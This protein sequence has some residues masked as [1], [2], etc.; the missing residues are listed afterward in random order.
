VAALVVIGLSA[1]AATAALAQPLDPDDVLAQAAAQKSAPRAGAPS[2]PNPYLSFLPVG[3]QPDYAAWNRWLAERGKEKRALQPRADPTKLIL[4]SES[5]PNGTQA[6]ADAVP[7]FGSGVGDDPEAD[8]PGTIDPPPAPTL[9]GPSTEDEGSIPLARVVAIPSGTTL[10]TG[11]TVGDGPYASSGTG[12]GDFDFYAIP[13]LAA[14]DTILIDVDTPLPFCCDLDP[15][16]GIWDAA[17]NLLAFNDD[18]PMGGT[19]DSYLI[20]DVPAA[21][22][23]YVSMGAYLRPFPSNPFDS[24]S[25]LG[26]ASEGPYDLTLGVNVTDND[27]YSLDLEPGD[28]IAANVLATFGTRVTL[29]DPTAVQRIG[30]GQEVSVIQP[31]P[32]PGGGIASF[33][34]VVETAGTHAVRVGNV[35]GAYTLELRVLR[36]LLE[37]QLAGTVQ[38][39]FVDFDGATIDRAIFNA[40]PASVTLSPLSAFLAGWGLTPADENAVIDGVLDVIEENLSS[41]VRVFGANGD[42]D[43]TNLPGDFDVVILNSRDHADPFGAPNVSRLII[44]GTIPELGLS[45]IGIAESIDPG[46]FAT[47]ETAVVLLDLLSGPSFDPNSLNQF[48]VAGSATKVDLVAQG[49]GNVASHEAGHF[50]ANWH[51]AQFNALPCIMD[52]GGNLPG[53]VGVGTDLTLGTGDDVDVDLE[54]DTYVQGEG[55]T[56]IEDTLNAVAFGLSTGTR[57]CP[58]TPLGT[59]TTAAKVS[60]LIKDRSPD[61]K[62]SL[63]F[64][65]QKGGTVFPAELGDPTT[66]ADYRI[67]V[68]DADGLVRKATAP[69]GGIC[70]GKPCWKVAGTGFLY[71]DKE[72]TP[73]GSQ[74]ITIKSGTSPRPKVIWKAKGDPLVDGALGLTL[75]VVVEVGHSDGSACFGA[76]F[77]APGLIK[78]TTEE[79]KAKAP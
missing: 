7:G 61:T 69:A 58:P 17:G 42:Y 36:P 16:V 25:G 49:L 34:Y 21:G 15:F 2:G 54:R 40:T 57:D 56:G 75:P 26:F 24:S 47:S 9:V 32:F 1:T 55:F 66:T 79:F 22:T 72:L 19:Y 10:K 5:E 27:F 43:A 33:A 65:W 52:Q 46:N 68:Y 70:D 6:S 8:L 18:Q 63:V 4:G 50:F 77:G 67:C 28:V 45:T 53:I 73:D 48:A 3:E 12:S 11:G 23:Y 76:T 30:S 38:T 13:G 39:L 51:T 62:D 29:F 71:R 64:K 14:G 44:G 37:Q 60:L 78:N 20:F 74:S 31:G 35:P 41:D 59:C